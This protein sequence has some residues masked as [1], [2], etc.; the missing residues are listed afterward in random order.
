MNTKYI[1]GLFGKWFRVAGLLLL[2]AEMGG[3]VAE[4][5]EMDG[6]PAGNTEETTFTVSVPG[7]KTPSTRA[8]SAAKEKEVSEIDVVIFKNGAIAEYHRVASGDISDAVEGG[9]LFKVRGV[10]NAENMTVSV[11]ANASVEV[12]AALTAV[13]VDGSYAGAAKKDFLSA[14]QVSNAMKWNTSAGNYWKIPMYGEADVTENIYNSPT[15][16]VRL[17]RMLAKV[18]VVNGVAP[19]G[20][21]AEGD[22]ELTAV[23][24][25]NYNARGLVAPKWEMTTG[26]PVPDATGANL[27]EGFDPDT[28]VWKEGNELTYLLNPGQ[29]SLKNEIYLFESAALSSDLAAPAGTRLVFEGRYT[30]GGVTKSYY[31]P[32]DFTAPHD[33]QTGKTD[34]MPVLRNNRYLFMI[35]EAAGRGYDR[36]GDAVASFGVMSNLKISLIVV[37][38]TDIR[39]MVWN[40]EY[41]LG[42]S[43]KEVRM[44]A[45]GGQGWVLRVS[46]NVADGWQAT[47]EDPD[48]NSWLRF[49]DGA[50]TASGSPAE[51]QLLLYVPEFTSAT[52]GQATRTADIILT[53]GR[54]DMTLTVT[55]TTGY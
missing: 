43:R 41:F 28:R 51:K 49:A 25:V 54:L 27:P 6:R 19:S 52:G 50:R 42:V 32:A 23:H 14:L 31:Y 16:T 53:A 24:V 5:P 3:C 10:E 17:T 44:D 34:Y 29:T 37:D 45:D 30:S 4:Y 2:A 13:T 47:I 40:G 55:Q 39:H 21:P 48:T 15:P 11:I 20:T 7:M 18:D 22:F 46:T 12:S 26:V 33:G 35:T 36:L 9:Y 38:E 8:L 1:S